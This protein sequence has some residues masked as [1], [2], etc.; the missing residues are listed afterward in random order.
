MENT[1]IADPSPWVPMSDP[2]SLKVLGKFLEEASECCAATGWFA[3]GRSQFNFDNLVCEVAD[4]LC[5]IELV[6][7][8]FGLAIDNDS[9]ARRVVD[10][11]LADLAIHLGQAGAAAARCL[12]QGIDEAEPSTGEVNREWLT[13]G[14]DNLRGA[15]LA[16]I[17]S[18]GMS[19]AAIDERVARKREFLLRWHAMVVSA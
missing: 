19:V 13:N 16:A 2:V 17:G 6:R 11:P 4:V 7:Q 3:A 5:N 8:H 12:I 1:F 15:L 10:E 9:W 18:L 14:L